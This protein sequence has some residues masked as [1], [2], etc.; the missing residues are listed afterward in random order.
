MKGRL[1]TGPR[2]LLALLVVALAVAV[3][4]T[5]RKPPVP[6]DVGQV[7]RGP[8]TM[9]VDDLGET[10]VRDLY[11]VS[12]PVTG[13]LLRVPLK[14][15]TRVVPHK[16][17]LAEIQPMAPGPLDARAYAQAQAEVRSL[18]DRLSAER[19]RISELRADL[20]LAERDFAR[21]SELAGRGFVSTANLDR[22]RS[23]RDRG[24]AAVAEANRSAAAIAHSLESAR[25]ALLVAGTPAKGAG[26]V[27]VTSPVGGY[28]LRVPQES[29][30]A[31]VA[32]TPLVE[33]GDP[34]NLEI[35]TDLLSSDA[36]R[37]KPGAAVLIEDW[38]GEHPLKG[39]VRLVE[40]YGFT[41]ISALGVEE[42]R[43]NVVMDFT[44]PLEAI[45][46]LGHGY[47]ATVRIATWS[48]PQVLK[49]PIS[50][51]FRTKGQ[52]T[53]F[54]VGPGNRARLRTVT[55]GH[56]N[57]QEAEVLGGLSAGE[58]VLLHPS[59]KVSDGVK[60]AERS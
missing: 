39:R 9:S 12:A 5:L 44:E 56:T 34:K 31:V 53:V 8:M 28:V 43:V 29:E 46:R 38:G 20:A 32:G 24:R 49:V 45:Q 21:T 1:I 48:A 16:T 50:A 35:V 3:G 6:V 14:P 22:A 57:D 37:V 42:Q 19:E 17:I 26:A 47:R 41:K 11:V 59:D 13:Q 60:I 23:A 7:T 40:P 52:W 25:A 30:R 10:R 58:K 36:V 55:I 27:T 18:E 51:L 33:I 4:F 15:G 2:I 54:A